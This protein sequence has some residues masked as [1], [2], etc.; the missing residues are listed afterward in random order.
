MAHLTFF[1]FQKIL[2]YKTDIITFLILLFYPNTE[3]DPSSVFVASFNMWWTASEAT[4]QKKTFFFSVFPF[5]FHLIYSEG[6]KK[7]CGRVGWVHEIKKKP[8]SKLPF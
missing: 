5:F 6:R 1:L 2:I 7:N 4:Q 8:N 3:N